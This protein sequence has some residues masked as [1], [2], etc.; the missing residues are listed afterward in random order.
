MISIDQKGCY[1]NLL[2]SLKPGFRDTLRVMSTHL[3]WV[4]QAEAGLV[5]GVRSSGEATSD[6]R[7]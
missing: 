6:V 7:E 3:C 1:H 4:E 2:F 5:S